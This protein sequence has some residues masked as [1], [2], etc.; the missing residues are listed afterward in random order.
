MKKII[1]YLFVA[2]LMVTISF[3]LCFDRVGFVLGGLIALIPLAV[4][5]MIEETK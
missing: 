2:C 5:V 3:G 1:I 4:F